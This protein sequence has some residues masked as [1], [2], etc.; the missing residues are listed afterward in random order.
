MKPNFFIIGAPKAGTTSL[1]A[2]LRQHP[3]IFMPD[4]KEP[5]FFSRDEVYALGWEWYAKLFSLFKDEAA[6]GE[7]SPSYCMIESFPNV[8]ERIANHVPKSRIIYIVRDPFERV[9]SAW[10]QFM[11]TGHPVKGIFSKD[12]R[13]Y[14]PMV[15][16]SLYWQTIKAYKAYFPDDQIL[17][18][19]FDDLRLDAQKVAVQC[20]EFLKVNTEFE[21]TDINRPHNLSAGRTKER[22]I[23]SIIRESII[24]PTLKAIIP[25]K[26]QQQIYDKLGHKELPNRPDWDCETRE[27]F[28][29]RIHRDINQ[30]LEYAGKPKE[31]W[32]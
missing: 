13:E 30:F 1:W 2:I 24:F 14:P 18:L 25:K 5:N 15:E 12:I 10:L 3:D 31:Y 32:F 21:A 9:E 20:Y 28:F 22:M 7:A 4:V 17:I 6:I 26:L 11:Y 8:V 23:I 29:E 16:Q 27:W 19:F